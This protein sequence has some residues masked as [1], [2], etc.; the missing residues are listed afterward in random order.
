MRGY[1]EEPYLGSC[2]RVYVAYGGTNC[3]AY[4]YSDADGN[5]HSYTYCDCH[6][7]ADAD[8]DCDFDAVMP[9]P[10][11]TFTNLYDPE[12]RK[13]F[14]AQVS[15]AVRA[16]GPGKKLYVSKGGGS[17]HQP[18]EEELRKRAEEIA[19]ATG[20]PVAVVFSK[21]KETGGTFTSGAD[22]P[23]ALMYGRG[24]L[25]ERYGF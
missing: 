7:D 19:K 6:A 12:S 24:P 20:A 1:V 17:A 21:L 11:N 25:G 16:A 3:D 14:G 13:S 5:G 22:T 10:G 23:A 2:G 18:T 4:C 9:T 8:S 15:A